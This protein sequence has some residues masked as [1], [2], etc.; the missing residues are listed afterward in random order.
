MAK[1]LGTNLQEAQT[2]LNRMQEEVSVEPPPPGASAGQ[3][4]FNLNRLSLQIAPRAEEF[5]A[6]AKQAEETTRALNDA[7]FKLIDLYSD[8][9]FASQAGKIDLTKFRQLPNI[10]AEKFGNYDQSR[11]QLSAIGRLS[12]DL[13]GPVSSFEQGF[14]ALDA[15]REILQDWIAAFEEFENGTTES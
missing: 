5:A 13:R 12:R 15:I 7:L 9:T 3:R 11:E 10:L 8:P 4:L 2:A 6:S 14:D 1:A